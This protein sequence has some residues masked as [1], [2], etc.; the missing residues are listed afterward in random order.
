MTPADLLQPLSIPT[1]IWTD[2]SIDFVEGLPPSQG[3]TII[4]V[5]VD[6]LS[7]YSHFV[8]MRH[9]FTALSLAKY[10]I[11]NIVK[12]HSFPRSIISDRD[13]I[14]ICSFWRNLFQLQGTELKMSSSYHSQTDGQTEVTNRTLE[15]Y[16]KCFMGDQPKKW[17]EWLPWAEYSYNTSVHSSTKTTPFE[18]VYRVSPPSL[19]TYVPGT[20]HVEA[21][22][23]YLR[24]RTTILRDLRRNLLVARD[25]MK[26]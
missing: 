13:K 23:K 14:F 19:M 24:Y 20:T 25:R 18:A 4:M 9:P 12:L 8:P 7:K 16:V 15:Q 1:I 21:I 2:L 5:V 10:F 22:D 3:Y 17:F 6:R 26:T 11:S